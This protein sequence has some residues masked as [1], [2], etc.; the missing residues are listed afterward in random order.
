MPSQDAKITLSVGPPDT[1][2]TTAPVP[3]R[4]M[5]SRQ[6]STGRVNSELAVQVMLDGNSMKSTFSLGPGGA[7]GAERATPGSTTC[8]ASCSSTYATSPLYLSTAQAM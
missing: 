5:V 4:S 2:A 1:V 8:T 6:E 3:A 7:A